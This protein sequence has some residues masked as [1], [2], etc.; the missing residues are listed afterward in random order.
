M[1]SN[2]LAII[3]THNRLA[4]LKRCVSALQTQ[5]GAEAD[6]LIVD[7]DSTDGTRAWLEATPSLHTLYQKNEGSAGGFHG[8]LERALAMGY[9]WIWLMDDDG[10]PSEN[11]LQTLLSAP[12]DALCRAPIVY[13][14]EEPSRTAFGPVVTSA[15]S[16]VL[17]EEINALPDP[18]IPDHVNPFNGV[19]LHRSVVEKAGLPKRE[20]FIWGDEYEYICR[21]RAVGPIA[22]IRD[23]AFF[24]PQD[25]VAY[26]TMNLFGR[27]TYFRTSASKLG[28]YLLIRNFAYIGTTQINT[29]KGR[30]FFL[31]RHAM[32]HSLH[33]IRKGQIL[34][35]VKAPLYT[36]ES[37]RL[38]SLGYRRFLK[39]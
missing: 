15:G 31:L 37:F 16:L 26:G 1:S 11:C 2:V 8:G 7:N 33:F 9:E 30:A 4:L 5:K 21:V 13:S 27:K 12:T 17:R 35:A 20:L 23:A 25:R 38:K 14:E 29:L 32:A 36:V 28:T 22:A 10:V 18:I 3:V 39:P 6:I 19:L 24:H 34:L